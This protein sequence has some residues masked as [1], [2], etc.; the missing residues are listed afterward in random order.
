MS[1]RT[2]IKTNDEKEERKLV[3]WNKIVLEACEQSHQV[4]RCEVTKPVTIKEL[5]NY[6]TDINLVA[7][8][9]E[10]V[11]KHMVQYLKKDA[12]VMIVIG[13]EGGFEEKEIDQM[14]DMGIQPCSLGKRILRAETAGLY[15]LSVL[16]VFSEVEL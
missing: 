2:I 14:M 1:A 9:K 11:S 3:R 13:P 8:E 15:A 16:D 7:Y 12:G 6:F 4:H 10:A 5:S